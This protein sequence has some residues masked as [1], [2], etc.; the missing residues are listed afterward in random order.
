MG[1]AEA[2]LDHRYEMKVSAGRSRVREFT[3]D[4]AHLIR[5]GLDY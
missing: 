2:G 3:Q 4:D 5:P 1:L